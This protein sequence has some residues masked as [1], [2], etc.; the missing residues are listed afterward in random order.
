[1]TW[2]SRS[3]YLIHIPVPHELLGIPDPQRA[4]PDPMWLSIIQKEDL[5]WL[6][7]LDRAAGGFLP[8]TP[9]KDVCTLF[10]HQPPV[11]QRWIGNMN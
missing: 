5:M 1:M 6:G 7:Y 4:A 10:E 3:P 2:A 11:E 8:A 9:S